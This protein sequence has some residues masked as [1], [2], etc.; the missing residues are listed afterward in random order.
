MTNTGVLNDN[1][2]NESTNPISLR[3]PDIANYNI[4]DEVTG[5]SGGINT[6][7]TDE[8]TRLNDK[9]IKINKLYETHKRNK[10]FKN[11]AAKRNNAYWRMFMV[12]L[13]LAIIVVLLYMFRTNFPFVPSW[14]MDLVLIAVVAG[15]FIY[16]FIMYEDIMKRDLTDFDKLDPYSPAMLRDK[17]I[18][19]AEDLL[20]KGKISASI[21]AKAK[22]EDCQGEDCCMSGTYFKNGTCTESFTNCSTSLGYSSI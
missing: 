5:G 12:L 4:Y 14:A 2:Y 11:S 22:P 13:L 8:E 19:K 10:H 3:N 20:D 9:E 15:G 21:V 1:D 6:I 18:K 16:M 7:L 17:Q